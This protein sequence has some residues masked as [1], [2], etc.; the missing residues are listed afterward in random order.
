MLLAR[1][2]PREACN[3]PAPNGTY[4]WESEKKKSGGEFVA[5]GIELLVPIGGELVVGKLPGLL[6]RM[7]ESFPELPGCGGSDIRS[8]R[9]NW[10]LLKFN[11]PTD[12]GIHGSGGVPEKCFA[13]GL[14]PSG[15]CGID[16]ETRL[17]I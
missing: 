1:V 6:T 5:A 7:S 11:R 9:C 3:P 16:R 8:G 15:P 12:H 2:P 10:L 14:R 17:L 13:S 4:V